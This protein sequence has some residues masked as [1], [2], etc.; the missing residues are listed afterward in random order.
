MRPVPP[1]S[2]PDQLRAGGHA[3]LAGS[4]NGVTVALIAGGVRC[5]SVVVEGGRVASWKSFS[6]LDQWEWR[7]AFEACG[8]RPVQEIELVA[9]DTNYDVPDGLRIKDELVWT[10][11][12]SSDGQSMR[13]TLPLAGC[14]NDRQHAMQQ[15]ALLLGHPSFSPIA[16][17]PAVV[18]DALEQLRD[19]KEPSHGRRI[20]VELIP[21]MHRVWLES[22]GIHRA[23]GFAN[24]LEQRVSRFVP[25]GT[26]AIELPADEVWL[27]ESDGVRAVWA[28]L[29]PVH[30]LQ[31]TS[32]S[33]S[34]WHRLDRS[35]VDPRSVLLG[36]ALTGV[37]HPVS[38]ARLT[39]VDQID[40][41]HVI[42]GRL[43]S[44]ST[45][46]VLNDSQEAGDPELTSILAAELDCASP[47]AFGASTPAWASRM[48]PH[49][50]EI[51]PRVVEVSQQVH[52]RWIVTH[53]RTA[54]FAAGDGSI[55]LDYLVRAGHTRGLVRAFDSGRNA[56]TL[57]VDRSLHLVEELVECDYCHTSTCSNCDDRVES[58]IVC[59]VRRCGRCVPTAHPL[60]I[61][62]ACSTLVPASR[63]AAR[64]RAGKGG[65]LLVGEDQVHRV[66]I[67]LPEAGAATVHMLRGER[68]VS[69]PLSDT[70]VGY[71]LTIALLAEH[72]TPALVGRR[73]P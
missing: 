13:R 5:E 20:R 43:I 47:E 22:N 7:L 18:P 1:S 59:G 4:F 53:G 6:S 12:L 45:R 44:R 8:S 39:T 21:H 24:E 56:D 62:V 30:L 26:A 41:P 61:C 51:A 35:G 32:D 15:V 73:E 40:G 31:I 2:L 27:S 3:V 71:A 19:R 64:R 54:L 46:V 29:G 33:G 55:Q 17:D 28:T 23:S 14:P 16:C 58:C 42:D 9:F 66:E 50:P 52:E 65:S 34:V 48:L 60:P 72:G 25:A 70:G 69:L 38:V 68:A 11:Q 57:A 37:R 63:K 49:S 36:R 10:A 67:A